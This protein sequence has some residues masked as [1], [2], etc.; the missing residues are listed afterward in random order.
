MV[1]PPNLRAGTGIAAVM[2][3]LLVF[4]LASGEHKVHKPNWVGVAE[5]KP[6]TLPND[7]ARK[8]I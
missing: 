7:E 1:M 4:H 8:E 2:G 3:V 5:A 6:K